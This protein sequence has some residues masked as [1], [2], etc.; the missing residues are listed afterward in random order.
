MSIFV[1]LALFGFLPFA[2]LLFML[3]PARRAV[4]ATFILGWLFLPVGTTFNLPG[5]PDYSKYTAIGLAA[6]LGSALFDSGRLMAFRPRW[7]DI[8]ALLM[9]VI[10][11]FSSITNGLGAY[12]GVSQ[13]FN[14][15][16]L[17]TA[18]YF[19]ARVYYSDLD[20]ARD[21]ATLIIIGALI[22]TPLCLYEVKMSPQLHRTVYGFFPGNFGMTRRMGGWRPNVFLEHGLAVGLWMCCAAVV[23]VYLW[24]S[25]WPRSVAT[26]P[27]WVVVLVLL[28]AAV[29][30][31][32]FGAIALMALALSI[33]I[34][35]KWLRLHWLVVLFVMVPVLYMVLRATDLWDGHQLVDLARDIGG[36]ER[37]G[38][39]M[40]RV[41]NETV[42]VEKALR[43]PLF[44]WG[45]WG[46]NRVSIEET[47]F[48]SVTD[49]LWVVIVGQR[50]LAGLFAMMGMLLMPPILHIVRWGRLAM[51]HPML[52][53]AT[54]LCLVLIMFVCDT[55]FNGF[56]S[57]VYLLA[58]GAVMG[59]TP[60]ART[61]AVLRGSPATPMAPYP[62]ARPP[63]PYPPQYP[64]GQPMRRP[65]PHGPGPR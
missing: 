60:D 56:V 19:L 38:S 62:Y 47:G 43:Q 50:G 41:R 36:G 5:L 35:A 26:I 23:S 2:L 27:M 24:Q 12:D 52:A 37:S 46:R 9:L 49:A 51:S 63:F 14:A 4:A 58:A 16:C 13:M 1:P 10:P 6:V 55:L 30:C 17:W 45:T 22:Y 40:V 65:H 20:G 53:P 54:A 32:S 42:L 34:I 64:P 48:R 15:F 3:M 25:K 57:P 39:L 28:G 21:L 29:A 11:F 31:K 61:L 7:F 18:P 44:G 8:P 59:L 33:G